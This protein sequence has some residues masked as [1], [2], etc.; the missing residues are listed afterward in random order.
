[1]RSTAGGATLLQRGMV[2]IQAALSLVLLVCGGCGNV[3]EL[4]E[5]NTQH[6]ANSTCRIDSCK[7]GYMDCDSS[8]NNG[9]EVHTGA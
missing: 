1:M 3:C 6:C 4:Y 8:P 2:V 5:T 7:D 9:C